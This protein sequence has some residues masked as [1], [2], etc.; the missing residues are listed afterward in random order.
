MAKFELKIKAREMR[1]EGTSVRTISKNLGIAKSTASLWTRDIILSVEQ[2]QSLRERWIKGT[3]LGRLKG[4]LMQKNRRLDL[5][6]KRKKEGMDRLRNI[7][8]N[9]FFIAGIALYWA[10]GSKKNR[11]LHLCNSD[12]DMIVFMIAWLKKFFGIGTNRL[13]AVVGINEIHRERETLVKKYWS[14]I[15]GIPL[16]QFRRTSFKKVK[17]NKVYKNFND[18]YGTLGIYVLK[19]SE[20]YYKMLGLITG[21][22]EAGKNMAG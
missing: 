10:E 5:I 13:K 21:L 20:F 11:K 12:P 4:A 17:N 16:D 3:E 19:G 14:E 1:S 15:T 2:L 6:E 8:D 22:S 18:H 7:S 9:E